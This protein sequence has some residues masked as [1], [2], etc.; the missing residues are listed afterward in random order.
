MGLPWSN[1]S[2]TSESR[3]TDSTERS[4][5][6]MARFHPPKLAYN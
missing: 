4:G 1:S 2:A 5:L 6:V 3:M